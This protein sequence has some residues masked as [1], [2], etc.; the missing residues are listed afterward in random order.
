[1]IEMLYHFPKHHRF[2]ECYQIMGNLVALRPKVCQE[3]IENCNSIKV[4]RL[5]LFRADYNGHS[6]FDDLNIN[7]IKLRKGKR[8]LVENGSL[9]KKYNIIVPEKYS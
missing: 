6:W 4:K 3:L 2:A 7:K 1:M 5:F 9:N 8:S